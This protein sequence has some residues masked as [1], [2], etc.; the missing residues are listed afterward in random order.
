LDNPVAFGMPKEASVFFSHSPTFQIWPAFEEGKEA[1]SIAKYPDENIMQSGWMLGEKYLKNK[2]AALEVPFGEGK[3]ILL[4]FRVQH[5]GQS[6]ATFK[7]LFNA[8]F[9]GSAGEATTLR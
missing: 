1:Q 4:G 3:I 5:R 2:S 6:V 9:Y 7:L 8:L